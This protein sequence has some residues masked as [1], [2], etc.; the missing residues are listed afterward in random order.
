[1]KREV[2][3]TVSTSSNFT[4]SV[5]RLFSRND[6]TQKGTSMPSMEHTRQSRSSV[7]SRA[8]GTLTAIS[9]PTPCGLTIVPILCTSLC[10]IISLHSGYPGTKCIQAAVYI[11]ISAVYLADVIYAAGAVGTHGCNEQGYTCTYI[12]R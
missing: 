2:C 11:L 6:S 5:V 1:M 4:S 9:P 8:A 7:Q 10:S 12:G 3:S